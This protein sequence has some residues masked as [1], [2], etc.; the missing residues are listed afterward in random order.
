MPMLSAARGIQG[1]LPNTQAT[2]RDQLKRTIEQIIDAELT[3]E[4]LRI[5]VQ[6]NNFDWLSA[7]VSTHFKR[8]KTSSKV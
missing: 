1:E 2:L 6:K 3:D 5:I 8:V 4:Q 7:G